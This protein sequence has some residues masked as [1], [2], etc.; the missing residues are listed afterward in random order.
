MCIPTDVVEGIVREVIF[1]FM[2]TATQAKMATTRPTAVR[3]S[4]TASAVTTESV[5]NIM[6]CMNTQCLLKCKGYLVVV[7]IICT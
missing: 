3:P 1:P 2:M 4:I 5:S 7:A 6:M